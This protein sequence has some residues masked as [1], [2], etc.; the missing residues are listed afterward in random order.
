MAANGWKNNRRMRMSSSLGGVIQELRAGR[1][2]R[3]EQI[4]EIER[5]LD[6]LR[7]EGWSGFITADEAVRAL[8]EEDEEDE[9]LAR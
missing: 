5:T 4:D 2:L 9:T 1:P 3:V 6:A 7:A 8:S